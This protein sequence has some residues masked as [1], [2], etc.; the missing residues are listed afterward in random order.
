MR[1]QTTSTYS[2]ISYQ[3]TF[4]LSVIQYRQHNF[5]ISLWSLS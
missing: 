1:K 3:P 5:N 2:N 4:V